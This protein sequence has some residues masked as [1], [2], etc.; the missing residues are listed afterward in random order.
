MHTFATFIF[1]YVQSNETACAH[2]NIIFPAT[3]TLPALSSRT[4]SATLALE[5]LTQNEILVLSQNSLIYVLG[6]FSA[7]LFVT[8]VGVVVLSLSFT[9]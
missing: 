7:L 5:T 1:R 3:A 9:L 6:G 8:L 4:I 2:Y